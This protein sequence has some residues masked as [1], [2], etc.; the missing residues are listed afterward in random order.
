[1]DR[2]ASYAETLQWYVMFGYQNPDVS[3]SGIAKEIYKRDDRLRK[4][5]QGPDLRSL[6]QLRPTLQLGCG[7][8]VPHVLSVL[9]TLPT[10]CT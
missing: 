7:F 3:I 6:G 8:I 5:P 2:H 10:K 1:M 9:G 4:D